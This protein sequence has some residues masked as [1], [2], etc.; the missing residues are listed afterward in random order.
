MSAGMNPWILTLVTFVPLAG[1]LA[2][3]IIPRRDS[4]VRWWAQA[5]WTAWSPDSRRS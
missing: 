2:L 3:L 1:A 4:A 5:P